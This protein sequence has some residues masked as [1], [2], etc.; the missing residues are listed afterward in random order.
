MKTTGASQATSPAGGV[1]D[2][3]L[4][5]LLCPRGLVMAG[6]L[7]S[8]IGFLFHT[9]LYKQHLWSW[10][11]PADWGHAYFIPLISLYMIY[12]HRD[13][14]RKVKP[15][16]YWPGIA[17]LLTGVMSY[18]I[19]SVG[20]M[21]NHMFQGFSLI[22]TIFGVVLLL[23]GPGVMRHVFVPIAYLVFA[24]T[25]SEKIMLLITFPLQLVASQGAWVLLNVVGLPFGF[26]ADVAGNTLSV[27]SS[28]G[29]VHPLNVAEA[30]SGM[31]MVI[32]FVALAG[33][34]A[35]IACRQWWQR[36]SLLMLSVPVALLMNII[37]VTVL[38]V[39]VLIDPNLTAG[40]AHTAIGTLLLIPALGLFMLVIWLLNNLVSD[41][42][43]ST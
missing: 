7:T 3:A 12:Q 31:R 41:P 20:A 19:F 2:D 14:L 13:E 25:I 1:V 21:G 36:V 40:N 43:V 28:Q 34:V 30:C 26:S 27:I 37:R 39:L 42:E 10:T 32:A 23:A 24:I 22:L 11:K 33:A 16:V 4:G 5:R 15:E 18:F 8:A 17:P 6:I 35:L 38:G 29:E 9:W